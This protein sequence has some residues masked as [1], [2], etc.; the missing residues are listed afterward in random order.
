MRGVHSA[1]DNIRRSV[2]TEVAKLAYESENED[3]SSIDSV[4]Y[5]I[6][7][8]ELAKY[9][10]DIFLER[11][12]VT[13]RLRLALGMDFSPE[14][15]E[16]P[17]SRYINEAATDQKYFKQPLI[18]VIKYACNACPEKQIR[19]TDSCQGCLSHPCQNVC[20]KDAI[21]LDEGEL[22]GGNLVRAF[23]SLHC[24]VSFSSVKKGSSWNWNQGE[25]RRLCLVFSSFFLE[26]RC[27]AVCVNDSYLSFILWFC[28]VLSKS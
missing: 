13:A 6:I 27:G 28:N 11:A 9:R 7:P 2:F 24:K 21:Y 22:L 23:R 10:R 20:P 3:Y 5:R 18:N 25:S 12:V 1:V 16:K 26:K 17:I 14:G 8:G 4:P 15:P 19:I